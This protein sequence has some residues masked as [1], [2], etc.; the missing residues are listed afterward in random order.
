MLETNFG[1]KGA[2]RMQNDYAVTCLTNFTAFEEGVLPIPAELNDFFGAD[3]PYEKRI[4]FLF[5]GRE[6]P[7]YVE[8]EGK[9]ITG[10]PG[11][12]PSTQNSSDSFPI[13][14]IISAPWKGMIRAA[15]PRRSI[16]KK[17][18]KLNIW[19][20]SSCRRTTP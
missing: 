15:R 12:R 9:A 10:W 14:P 16:L 13:T 18:M 17:S 7:T 1:P 5:E 2:W 3:T 20:S 19:S 6:Y 4:V 11:A 8:V